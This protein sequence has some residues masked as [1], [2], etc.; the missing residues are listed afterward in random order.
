LTFNAPLSQHIVDDLFDYDVMSIE[1][2]GTLGSA[3]YLREGR[4]GWS[5]HDYVSG[6][7]HGDS[8]TNAFWNPVTEKFDFS[9][10]MSQNGFS[11]VDYVFINLGTNM[12]GAT[13]S[14]MAD[15]LDEM[16][17]SIH[18]YDSNIRVGVWT[19]PP[20]GINGTGNLVD[21]D[22]TLDKCEAI[23]GKFAGRT[24]E[25]VYVVP[26]TLNVDPYWDFPMQEVDASSRNTHKMWV[27]TD[28]TH[29]SN[30]GYFKMADVIYNYIKYFGSLD[31]T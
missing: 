27:I 2:I 18:T 7:T 24:S 31:A 23:I 22:R 12:D 1:L 21:N 30:A 4:S 10:Y 3:P 17:T 26:V 5:A 14:E 8:F 20:R 6:Y 29:P 11:N 16:V 15:D 25:R 28:N 9:Y 13:V 19:P